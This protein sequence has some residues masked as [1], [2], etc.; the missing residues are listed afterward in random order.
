MKFFVLFLFI[1][2]ILSVP[3]FSFANCSKTGTTI[4]FVNGI[5]GT[6]ESAKVDKDLLEKRFKS[7]VNQN[8]VTFINGFNPT[9]VYGLGDL[10]NSIMDAYGIN[11]VDYDLT[12]ILLQAHTDLKTQKILLVG[13]S[14]GTFYTN[15]A[16][17]YLVANGVD[18]NSIAVYN[19]ATPANKVAGNGNYL[20]SSTDGVI[21]SIVRNLAKAGNANKPLPANITINIPKEIV[22]D[23]EDGH[24]FSKV[25]LG[26]VPDRII[27]DID[28]ELNNLTANNSKDECFVAPKT[29]IIFN[30]K[31]GMY[32]FTDNVGKYHDAF[33]TSPAQGQMASIANSIFNYLHNLGSQ[34]AS[35]IGNVLAQNNFFGASL[36]NSLAPAPANN[37]TAVVPNVPAVELAV[38]SFE[39]NL[40]V[41]P[42]VVISQQDQLDDIQEKL[43][44][45]QQEINGLLPKKPI[46]AV[47]EAPET[48]EIP[49]Q[50]QQQTQTQT[51][52]NNNFTGGGGNFIN[53]PKIL[54][55][56]VQ[57]NDTQE[58]VELYNPNDADVDLT[59][60]Y[61]QRKTAG[62]QSW[63]TFASSSLFSGK[64]ISKNGY[65]L[66]AR[67]GYYSGPANIFVETAI[68]R[69]NSFALKNPNGDVSDK[70][71]FG[72]AQDSELSPAP[73]PEAGQSIGRKWDPTNNI[74][75]DTNNNFADFELE[76]PTPNAKNTAY[77]TPIVPPVNNSQ[78]SIT[79]YT[80]SNS[81]ISPDNDGVDDTTSIDLAFSED[82]QVNFD[83][84]NSS[85]VKVRDLYSS[86]KVKNP[87]AKIWDGKDNSGAVVPNGVYTL[88]V[89]ITDSDGNSVTDTSKTITVA[90][91]ASGDKTVP[92]ITLN[93]LSE[94]TIN[95]GDVYTDAGATALD[96]VDGDITA[97]IVA[98]N[99][100][101][102]NTIG[103][104]TI[105]YNVSDAAGNNAVQVTRLVHVVAAAQKILINEIQVDPISQRFVELY[106][107]NST[108]INLTGWYLQRKDKND[109]SWGT[110]VSS[111]N[112]KD[113][114][115]P[116]GGY[117]LISK[118]LA[119]SD[120]LSNITLTNDNS[121]A[122]KNPKGAIID[123]VG[124]GQAMDF[125][126]SPF[127]TNPAPGQSIQRRWDSVNNKAQ[128]TGNN[129][130]DFEIFNATTPKAASPRYYLFKDYTF[131]TNTTLTKAQSPYVF[132][133]NIEVN[134]GITLTI[135]PGVVIKFSVL[136]T[137]L[138][139]DGT[140]KAIG[141]D[142][143]KI[144]FT[145][146]QDDEYAGDIN[147]DGNFYSP[148][149]AD[150]EGIAIT[151]NSTGSEFN[152][153]ILKYGGY[154]LQQ[155]GA[156]LKV[157]S[158]SVSVKN[159]D[160]E[161]NLN[162]G[163]YLIDSTATVDSSQFLNNNQSE[164]WSNFETA[165]IDD[166]G[167][168]VQ[169]TNNY[170]KNNGSGILIEPNHN[171]N[172]A[173]VAVQNNSFEANM[174]IAKLETFNGP[175]FSGNKILGG[176][177]EPNTTSA[178]IL[179]HAPMQ[180]DVTLSPD[181]PYLLS[182]VLDVPQGM[183]LTL[184][185]GVILDFQ[186]NW[187]GIQIDGTL[188]AVGTES[189]PI[190]FRSYYYD[191]PST[192]PGSWLGLEF[193]KTS[194]NS[195]LENVDISYA[196]AFYAGGPSFGSGI[197]V[198][199]SS[200][201][202]KNSRIW[203]NPPNGVWLTNSQSVIDNVQFS[204][205]KTQPWGLTAKAV[206]VEGGSPEI[207]NSSFQNQTY[208]IYEDE[209]TDPGNGTLVCPAPTGIETDTFSNSD[210]Q[211]I[212]ETAKSITDC[213]PA[214]N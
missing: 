190:V 154:Y 109:T 126:T 67:T 193:T 35:G 10:Y 73:N 87:D 148:A 208:G 185:P 26:L 62:S 17:D 110:F 78:P 160:F 143:D 40:S 194:L 25:Y 36:S 150:W 57:P 200:I 165:A 133:G 147:G 152:N 38:N 155:F 188:K 187:A 32:Y 142:L 79:V 139:V 196:A 34:I 11:G 112:F 47:A 84:L 100:V 63:S 13:H 210:V 178:S 55:S 122:L 212:F 71:G 3:V 158:S 199:Q 7:Y 166:V 202:L 99:P 43:D 201:L 115:I 33:A 104:Y 171:T 74:Q 60:W 88:Q 116:A 129:S 169:I 176:N 130:V 42:P 22:P 107:P 117:F 167:G 162:R 92:V 118:E 41:P 56:E 170:F 20:T 175:S 146:F 181:V 119:N 140:I 59:N 214:G 23:S 153:A 138:T 14:Q 177:H 45:L 120:I 85:G 161:N 180:N 121:L 213:T 1:F 186:S 76:T 52:T 4:I 37:S 48:P 157:Q 203:E 124:F 103:D 134:Q 66:I 198:D 182:D 195:D 145:S 82:V 151:Q 149:G 51:S 15:A 5:F 131:S 39:N 89:V 106:N 174:H 44:I 163:L 24:S 132:Q 159:C 204:D 90:C 9:H 77:T 168:N 2:L 58:F 70:L 183:T 94:I 105:T 179:L 27:S 64:I 49:D 65:F 144:V 97:K 102:A 6:Q 19:V 98:V 18:K 101:D 135:E 205:N 96:D 21:N 173:N 53:Y 75:Q 111:T 136:T 128:D 164:E 93:G 156:V 209:W 8:D 12:N 31:G 30:I 189:N 83:I 80:I 95:V 123:K 206:Y 127:A 108:D 137:Y 141:T 114:I 69:D 50:T 72:S 61:F 28:Q 192:S 184:N 29:D 172:L 113:K 197:R 68:T 16:Y 46:V 86:S 207:K 125:Q 91:S 54:I 191:I 211:D 81:T